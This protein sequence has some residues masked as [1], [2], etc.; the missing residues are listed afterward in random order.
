MCLSSL[1]LS[2]CMLSAHWLLI[3]TLFALAMASVERCLGPRNTNDELLCSASPLL[4]SLMAAA[5][6][7]R[8]PRQLPRQ[9]FLYQEQLGRLR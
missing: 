5:T 8:P 1:V 7:I 2:S 3:P 9:I 4:P 6:C